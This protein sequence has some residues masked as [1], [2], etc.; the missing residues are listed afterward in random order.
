MVVNVTC[1]RNASQILGNS[2]IG[3]IEDMGLEVNRL[4]Y[5]RHTGK[6]SCLGEYC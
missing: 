6:A 5:G 1:S 2:A 3:T 4:G